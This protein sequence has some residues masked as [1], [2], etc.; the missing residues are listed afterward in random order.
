MGRLSAQKNTASERKPHDTFFYK[1]ARRD[2]NPLNQIPKNPVTARN[3]V[4]TGH[5]AHIIL[6]HYVI[7]YPSAL[8]FTPPCNTEMQHEKTSA[9]TEWQPILAAIS[10][11]SLYYNSTSFASQAL[12]SLRLGKISGSL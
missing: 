11:Y 2:S 6:H 3:L 4:I 8:H 10:F 5:A 12:R 9:R 1:S 7:K